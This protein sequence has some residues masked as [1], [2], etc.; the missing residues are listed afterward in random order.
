MIEYRNTMRREIFKLSSKVFAIDFGTSMLKIYKK[1]EGVIFDQK[2][3]VAICDNMVKA[4]GDEAFEM[5]GRTPDNFEVTFPV[6]HGV[7]ADFAN[8]LAMINSSFTS[9]ADK[10]GKVNGAEF[11]I[12]IPPRS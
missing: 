8:M 10:H 12:A 2:N 6:K 3:V 9:L 5:Y 1:N 11:I 7:I 4:I